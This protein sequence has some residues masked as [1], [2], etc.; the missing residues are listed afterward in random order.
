MDTAEVLE[1]L[2]LLVPDVREDCVSLLHRF[3]GY[4]I[5]Q[6]KSLCLDEPH[7]EDDTRSVRDEP[8]YEVRRHLRDDNRRVRAEYLF[9]LGTFSWF[10]FRG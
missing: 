1:G 6:D 2:F 9:V 5:V 10:S 4:K 3:R 8:N 7:P